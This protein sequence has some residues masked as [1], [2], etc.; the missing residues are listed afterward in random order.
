MSPTLNNLFAWYDP[1]LPVDKH[2]GCEGLDSNIKG[3]LPIKKGYVQEL[4]F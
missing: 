2:F 4:K 1:D 3:N